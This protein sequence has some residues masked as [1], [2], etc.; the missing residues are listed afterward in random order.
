M[1][2]PTRKSFSAPDEH[3]DFP[4]ITADVVEMADSSVWTKKDGHWLC[5]MHTET[6]IDEKK[7]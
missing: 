3:I 2:A 7:H 6:P 4:G 1:A 5:V